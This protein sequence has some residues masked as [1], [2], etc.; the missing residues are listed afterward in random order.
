MFALLISV[1]RPY[2]LSEVGRGMSTALPLSS[3]RMATGNLRRLYGCSAA[4]EAVAQHVMRIARHASSACTDDPDCPAAGWR[5]ALRR[6]RCRQA[7]SC[8]PLFLYHPAAT[9]QT[10]LPP[11]FP[12][13][14]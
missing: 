7:T 9:A 10:F 2:F 3:S 11:P 1:W 14:L 13:L 8:F 5:D 4:T 6:Y 12:P